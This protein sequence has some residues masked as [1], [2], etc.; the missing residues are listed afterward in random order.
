M[1]AFITQ[2][3][4]YYFTHMTPRV[5]LLHPTPVWKQDFISVDLI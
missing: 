3:D 4:F 1:N 5:Q 2:K